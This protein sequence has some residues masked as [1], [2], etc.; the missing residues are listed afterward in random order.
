LFVQSQHAV[1]SAMF[2]IGKGDLVRAT[3][4]LARGSHRRTPKSGRGA[5][6]ALH[7]LL[8]SAMGRGEDAYG[9]VRSALAHSQ[10]VETHALLAAGAAVRAAT[11]GDS[12]EC[13]RAYERIIVSGAVYALVLACR[14][15]YEVAETLLNSRDHRDDVLRLL[16]DAN[17]TAIVKRSGISV[18]RVADRRLGLSAREHEVCE[19]LAQGRTNHEI[20]TILFI[21]LS[22][23]KVHVKH[24]FEKLGV[25]SRVEA[26]RLWEDGC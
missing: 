20:A 15:R 21:S 10:T 26:G 7:A 11:E 5:R 12:A 4:H 19:L 9:E 1:Q 17:D 25:R 3:D 18:P 6:H 2:A 8:L 22:T 24:I 13:I 16:L 23:T 14:T